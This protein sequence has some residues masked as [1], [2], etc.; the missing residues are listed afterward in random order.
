VESAGK[1]KMTSTPRTELGKRKMMFASAAYRASQNHLPFD[2]TIDD[3]VIPVRCPVL[4]HELVLWDSRQYS[5]TLDRIIPSHGYTRGNICVISYEAN[6][7]KSDMT[8]DE[9]LVSDLSHDVAWKIYRYIKRHG[10]P[11]RSKS[12]ARRAHSRFMQERLYRLPVAQRARRRA[13]IKALKM[14]NNGLNA[15]Q[16]LGRNLDPRFTG[17]RDRVKG[18][19]GSFCP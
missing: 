4:G 12:C 6:T 1:G 7:L 5:P 15:G 11:Y 18:K 9:V 13:W 16:N 10:K 8:L 14:F 2:L 17:L 3:I 19:S